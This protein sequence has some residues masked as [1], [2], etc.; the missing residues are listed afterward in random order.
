MPRAAVSGG[1]VAPH[2]G[3]VCAAVL[4]IVGPVIVVLKNDL[5]LNG[6]AGSSAHPEWLD[7]RIANGSLTLNGNVTLNG[8]VTAP[9]GTVTINGNSTLTGGLAA[10]KLVVNGNGALI[11]TGH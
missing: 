1:A 11:E 6:I 2:E 9:S 8:Y 7:L 3:I 10:D 4:N 5:N